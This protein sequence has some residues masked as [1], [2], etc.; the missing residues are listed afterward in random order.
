MRGVVG[1]FIHL[2][3]Q[4]P[5]FYFLCVM[6]LLSIDDSKKLAHPTSPTSLSSVVSIVF[7]VSSNTASS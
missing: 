5:P 7:I 2:V 4:Y 3:V 1:V 6:S